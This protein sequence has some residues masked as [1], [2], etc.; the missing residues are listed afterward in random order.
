MDFVPAG[1]VTQLLHRWTQGD[2]SALESLVP[3]VYADLRRIARHHLNKE[4]PDHTLQ[5]TALINEVFIRLLGQQSLQWQNRKHFFGAVAKLMRRIL[6]DYA[7][8]RGADKRDGATMLRSDWDGAD[9]EADQE[10]FDL[11][12]LDEALDRMAAMDPKLCHIVEL[13]FF[14]GLEVEEIAQIHDVSTSTVKREWASARA[15]LWRELTKP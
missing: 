10:R 2:T 4:R 14:G 15:W 8:R 6:V 13:R 9:H 11:L 5:P 7:R 1:E 12:A 3:L